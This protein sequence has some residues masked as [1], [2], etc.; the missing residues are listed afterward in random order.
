MG[1]LQTRSSAAA[2]PLFAF[3]ISI[4]PKAIKCLFCGS[5]QAAMVRLRIIVTI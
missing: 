4:H 5:S 3:F 1:E 2:Q